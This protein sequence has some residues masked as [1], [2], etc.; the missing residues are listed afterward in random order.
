L[1][2]DEKQHLAFFDKNSKKE[3]SFREESSG[4]CNSNSVSPRNADVNDFF[5]NIAL[6][7]KINILL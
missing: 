4:R 6:K 3:N 7:E 5:L 1:F 2:F